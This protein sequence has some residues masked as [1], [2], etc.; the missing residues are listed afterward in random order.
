MITYLISAYFAPTANTTLQTI[1]SKIDFEAGD[2]EYK[3]ACNQSHV[4]YKEINQETY[5]RFL[6]SWK[7]T[8]DSN[9]L[10]MT[11]RLLDTDAWSDLAL[12][13]D[14]GTVYDESIL[15]I[16]TPTMEL[17]LAAWKQK[18]Y[19]PLYCATNEADEAVLLFS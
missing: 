14:D 10:S 19:T 7:G 4:P 16:G 9:K 18:G 3:V 8:R 2:D 13:K 12:K 1:F 15:A 11:R 17:W 5:E 6:L